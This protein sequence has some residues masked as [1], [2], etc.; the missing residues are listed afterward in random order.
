MRPKSPR[1]R[2]P[3]CISA[4]DPTACCSSRFQISALATLMRAGSRGN[5]LR[6]YGRHK[7]FQHPSVSFAKG[8]AVESAGSREHCSSNGSS[9]QRKNPSWFPSSAI[10][11]SDLDHLAAAVARC[12]TSECNGKTCPRRKDRSCETSPSPPAAPRPPALS[13]S[14]Q[15]EEDRKQK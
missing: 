14:L 6:G 1:G 12:P 5:D 2:R 10:R 11:L 8:S 4:A 9:R 3:V 7:R 13:P 15:P